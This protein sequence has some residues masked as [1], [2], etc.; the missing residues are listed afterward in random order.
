MRTVGEGLGYWISIVYRIPYDTI[1][2]YAYQCHIS[3]KIA[4]RLD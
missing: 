3:C 1:P 2:F 4:K